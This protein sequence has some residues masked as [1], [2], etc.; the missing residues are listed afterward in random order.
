MRKAWE[1]IK[2]HAD[3]VYAAVFAGLALDGALSKD[4]VGFWFTV[5]IGVFTLLALSWLRGA[6]TKVEV[7]QTD[8]TVPPKTF[9][10]GE[11]KML[12][13][14]GYEPIETPYEDPVAEHAKDCIVCRRF[15]KEPQ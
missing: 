14:K 15:L 5:G 12:L 2:A 4:W 11:M 13:A 10:E 8:D 6:N 7:V 9:E 3:W 1:F